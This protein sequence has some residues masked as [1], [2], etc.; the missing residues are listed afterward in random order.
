MHTIDG[1][2]Y[3]S[4][5]EAADYLGI[6]EGRIRQLISEELVNRIKMGNTSYVTV[7][8]VHEYKDERGKAGWPK[9]K[10]RK[11]ED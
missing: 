9:G 11:Q 5:Q 4:I 1:I 8:S 6:T 2:D 7:A 3:Y 10:P